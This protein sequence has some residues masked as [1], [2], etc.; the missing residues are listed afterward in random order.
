LKT[1]RIEISLV[2]RGEK[3]VK[4]QSVRKNSSMNLRILIPALA[5]AVFG[6]VLAFNCADPRYHGRSL[7][8]WLQQYDYTPAMNDPQRR[9]EAE[10]AVRAI[11]ARRAL[12]VL[13]GLVETKNDPVSLWLIDKSEKYRERLLENFHSDSFEDYERIRWHDARDFQLLGVA[14]FE[15]LGTNA[16]PAVEEL[17]KFLNDKDYDFVITRSLVSIGKPSE[18]VFCRALTNQD[19]DI[20]QWAIDQLASVTDDVGV[21]IGR[22]KP[23]LHDSSNGVRGTTV[24]AIGIQT[25]APELAIPLLVEALKDSAVSVNAVN[26]LANFGT[27]ALVAFPLLTNLVEHGDTNEAG[28]ALRTLIIIAPDKAFPIFTNCLAQGKPEIDGALKALTDVM[29]EKALP[30]LLAHLQSPSIKIRREAF[31]LLR[32]YPMTPQID[33]AIQIVATGSDLDLALATK[34]FLTEQYETNHPDALL[35]PDEP[36]CN[37]KRLGEWLVTRTEVGDELTPAAKDAFRQAGTNAI[38]ALL[39]RL[40]YTRP[41]YCFSPFQINMNATWGFIVLGGQAKPALPEL[42]VLMDSTNK[43]IALVAMIASCGTGSN[44]M[45]FFIKGMTNQFTNVRSLAASALT[46]GIGDKFPEQRK[47]AIPL[48]VKLLNDS[49]DDIRA[50][51]TNQLK[52]IDP[53]AAARAGIK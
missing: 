33:V 36:I 42:W 47:Q 37:G 50:A 7:T 22:I 38:P 29:P 51:A 31:G 41:S 43:D 21:Y 39:K 53:A 16:A 44:A 45:P 30:F 1:N 8:R 14:G 26:A 2:N 48:F 17:E 13:L 11:G 3:D 9:L 28:A 27:N 23:G 12:P 46:E 52:Q 40:T 20:R 6:I 49:D 4:A 10:E 35:F 15:I 34:S 19:P 25:S 24:D 18:P 32:H 5:I